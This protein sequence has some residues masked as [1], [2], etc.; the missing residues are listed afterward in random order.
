M[1]AQTNALVAIGFTTG[2]DVDQALHWASRVSESLAGRSRYHGARNRLQAVIWTHFR[3]LGERQHAISTAGVLQLHIWAK[4]NIGSLTA[5]QLVDG[6][7]FARAI[8]ILHDR[9]IIE[10]SRRRVAA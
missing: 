8:G 9:V 6:R 2:E 1:Q 10:P 3:V 4:D 5:K 7:Q